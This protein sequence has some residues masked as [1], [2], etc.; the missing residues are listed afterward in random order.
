MRI[1]VAIPHFFDL[2]GEIRRGAEHGA[3]RGDSAPR[4]EALSACISSLHQLFGGP[5]VLIDIARRE[6]KDANARF[7]AA[8]LDV[9]VCTTRGQHLLARLPLGGDA[10]RHQPTDAEPLLLG[11]ECHAALYERLGDYDYYC[12]LEDDL[13]FRDPWFF[14][15]LGWFH[16]QVGP[17]A[18][19]L[20][21]RYEVARGGV[22]W[23]A[24]LDGDLAA[25]VTAPFQNIAEIPELKG[26]CLG[27]ELSFRRP[28]NPH[29]GC[30]FLTGDQLRAWGTRAD[31]LDRDSRFIGP[32]ESA[33]T[34]GLM[35]AFRIYKP[36]PEVA[37]FLEIEHAG[38]AFI[39]NLRHRASVSPYGVPNR[40]NPA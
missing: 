15:K 7:A 20:P 24:Y 40:P 2:S 34:L 31:F 26:T 11:F 35:R 18:V 13:I 27:L 37:S 3:L 6:A 23:K 1:L 10:F 21:N 32:L 30:F 29:A 38:T 39:G 4:V 36:A 9:V 25:E 8:K 5:Q 14:A 33:A 22:A 17:G 28:L 19:L 16:S 12:Y